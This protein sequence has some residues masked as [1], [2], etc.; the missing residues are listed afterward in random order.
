M[1]IKIA[2]ILLYEAG[3]HDELAAHLA[4][5]ERLEM[6]WKCL[7]A[8]RALLDLRFSQHLLLTTNPSTISIFQPPRYIALTSFDYIF[9][10]L[11]CLRLSIANLPG[12][13]LRLVRRELDF[14]EYLARQQQILKRFAD[15]RKASLVVVRSDGD[16]KGDEGEGPKGREKSSSVV[17]GRERLLPPPPPEEFVDPFETLQLQ[18]LQLGAHVKAELAATMPPDIHVPP[19]ARADATFMSKESFVVGEEEVDD[20][21]EAQG[22]GSGS[23]EVAAALAPDLR[24]NLD[25]IMQMFHQSFWQDM[26]RVDDGNMWGGVNF[27]TLI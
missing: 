8:T 3:L 16:G 7:Q 23:A 18:I 14:N 13:D 26:D 9:S 11:T 4:P 21:D 15:M 12:W 17:G 22:G 24:D 5:P 2:E 27:D 20:D 25:E 1:Q 19:D 6:L 10:M